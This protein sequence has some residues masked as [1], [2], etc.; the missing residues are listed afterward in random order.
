MPHRRP[1]TWRP[2]WVCST[3][4]R[5]AGDPAVVAAIRTTIPRRLAEPRAQPPARSL[6]DSPRGSR[7]PGTASCPVP[8]TRPQG[9]PRRAAR[10]DGPRALPPPGSPT[11]PHVRAAARP[12]TSSSTPATASIWSLA[13]PPTASPSRTTT[14]SPP[15][16]ASRDADDV[17]DR[18]GRPPRAPSP[19]PSRHG[20]ARRPVPAR[21]H[22]ARR[23]APAAAQP[24][25]ATACSSTTARSSS[26]RAAP[27]RPTPC[28]RC[29]LP[30]SPRRTTC[31]SPR[32]RWPTSPA[33][34]PPLP[35]PWPAIARDLFADLLAAGPGLIP[36]GRG[37]TRPASS[38]AGCPSGPPCARRPQRNAG[39]PAHRGPA[40]RSR[41][42]SAPAG[43]M[44]E[45]RPARPAAGRR[46]AARHRQA[47]GRR[48]PLRRPAR[49]SPRASP[50]GW[51]SRRADVDVVTTLVR[52]HLT[53][54]DLATR[55]DHQDPGTVA[56][57]VE[58]GRRPREVLRPA[59]GA[60]RGRR[61]AAGPGGLD[62]LARHP[63]APARRSAPG[64]GL[65]RG[66]PAAAGRERRAG[67]RGGPQ[68]RRRG[69]AP[70]IVRP[71]AASYRIDVF[72]RDRLGLF[73]DTAGLLAAHG[74]VVRTAILRTVD[75]RRRR[76][77]AR[78]DARAAS[79]AGGRSAS[80]AGS[81]A[82]ARRPRAAEPARPR[83]RPAAPAERGQ[84]GTG[85]P[86]R[87]GRWSCRTP[88]RTRRSSRCA[89]RT[90]P[91]CSTSSAWGSRGP[92]SRCAS[93]HIATYAG[94]TLDT[95]YVTESGGRL[96][97]PAK[98]ARRWRHG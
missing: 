72:D 48:R 17:L 95:F 90:V 9:G 58:R 80:S 24:A 60:H 61:R 11:A 52:E 92:G 21:P 51:A 1:G 64:T 98:V 94:Q 42:S 67:R 23:S 83:R 79:A 89:P 43:L 85:R 34:P 46:A 28:S 31:R 27:C 44:R 82:R 62:R 25:R 54:I 87:P 13:A 18:G 66:H 65:G 93:A 32:P 50:P 14:R 49:R 3:C 59:R 70:V 36:S 5:V 8:R 81:P 56:A 12:A 19:T 74:L 53:L 29:A 20:T 84:A 77:V 40:P 97:P 88:P 7:T 57:V 38:T 47:A 63:A 55:R 76:R 10:R 30:S 26:G 86:A 2:R 37:S 22:P 41:P 91:G 39:P 33:R 35:D 68:P 16:S 69:G 15:C 4:G 96:L 75:G 45:R 73:A 6:I 71:R 78:R